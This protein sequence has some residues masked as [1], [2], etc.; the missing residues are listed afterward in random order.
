MRKGFFAALPALL[1]CAGVMHAEQVPVVTP[2][3][4]PAPAAV[5]PASG[6]AA[7]VQINATSPA[8]ACGGGCCC[9]CEQASPS[10]QLWVSG[11]YLLWWVKNGPLTVPLITTGPF[12]PPPG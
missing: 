1:A 6:P 8:P 11:E 7:P 4:A 12:P 5:V 10:S 9:G 3:A 2:G